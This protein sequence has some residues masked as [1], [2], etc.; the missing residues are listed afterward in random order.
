MLSTLIVTAAFGTGDTLTHSVTNETY[1]I[2]GPVDEVLAWDTDKEA[3]PE[4]KQTISL[5]DLEALKAQFAGDT[6]INAWLP[7]LRE[8]VPVQNIR[9]R[10]ND[11]NPRITASRELDTAP[12]GGL[13]DTAGRQVTLGMGDI[14]VN[15]EL[16]SNIEARVG[17][18]VLLFYRGE[19]IPLTVVAIVPNTLL[20]GTN[21]SA[22]RQGAAVNFD[23]L[24]A[25]TGR[26]GSADFV[27]I[28][29]EGTTRSDL[30]QSELVKDRLEAALAGTPYTVETIK[31]DNVEQA[32]LLGNVFTTVFVMFGL[33]SIAAGVLLIFLIFVMLAAERK[34]EMGMA[35]AVGAKRKQIVESFLA[36]GMGYD[37][38]SAVV[39]MFA[40][41]GVAAAM[42]YF[43]KSR[44]GDA[45]GLDL[46]F[47]ISPRSLI[48]AVC[49]GIIITFVVVFFAS[50]RASR[51]NIVSAIRDLPESKPHN[52]E[53]ATAMGYLRGGLNGM[54]SFGFLIVGLLGI[55]RLPELMPFWLVTAMFG[56]AGPWLAMVRNHN[57]G[58][59]AAIR[60]VG[61]RLPSWP[62]LLAL[63]VVGIPLALIGYPLAMLI[64]RFTR[65]RRPSRVATGW[66]IAGILVAPV[67][68]A[69]S[70]LQDRKRPV[71][72]AVG[73][74][75][76]SFLAGILFVEWGLSSDRMAWFALGLSFLV[77]WLAVTLTY[78]RVPA[79]PVY[80]VSSVVLMVMWYLLP[81]GRL[82]FLFGELNADVEMFFVT[83]AVLITAGTFIIIYNA[84]IILPLLAR[85][86]D[87]FG[88]ITPAV[89]T[90]V[91]YP[92][93]S[94]GRTGLTIA[95]IGL[96]V[97]V[98]SM[99]SAMN[100][101][102]ERAFL[103]ADA[104]G[105]FD[106]RVLMN[107][108]NR[109]EDLI[110]TLNEANARP[111]NPR[112]VDTGAI[113][114]VGQVR[115]ANPGE[116]DIEDPDWAS[117]D[118]A[119]RKDDERWKHYWVAG[120]DDAFVQRQEIPLRHRAAGYETDAAV[121]D[122]LRN[123]A[124]LAIIPAVL[125]D[126]DGGFGDDGGG[127]D[128]LQLDS[129]LAVDGF[130]PYT[131]KL[132]NRS[133]GTIREVT[134]IGQAKDSAST[135]W[136]AIIVQRSV[137]ELTFPD[138]KG[139]E[140]FLSLKPGTDAEDFAKDLEST[141]VQAQADS[142]DDIISEFSAI[143]RT[144][145][146]MFQGFLALGLLVG[147]AA[148]GV[149]SL[150]AVVERR[151]QIGM[152][153]AIGYQR[154]MVQLSFLLESGFIALSGIVLGLVLGVS[155]AANLFT[156]GEFGSTTKGLAFT[157]P[158]GEILGMTAFAFV[159]AMVM[160]YLPARAA[161]R[162]AVAEALRYE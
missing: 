161:S 18:T 124:S 60:K 65:E 102:F 58:A 140:F 98:L 25:L 160:T 131:L 141:L 117:S 136:G 92:L 127:D 144:F 7:M 105:G 96:I 148:L 129:D 14:A 80:T 27:A 59:P 1:T 62:Y 54:A 122:A 66:L 70:A 86:G 52:P 29:N 39:G 48:V 158:W 114:A 19:P 104:K 21:D 103:G 43:V 157:V 153:R 112:P 138:S 121:W 90:A 63:T 147:I 24:A 77:L 76:V 150:R 17:D 137:V 5:T 35:R 34:P 36:E 41:I 11:A 42:V 154:S 108:N 110:A 68:A 135:F 123:D 23:F 69:L 74:A 152:L 109:T 87:R 45:L 149:I 101:N 9:T 10:L 139:Q 95:M 119:G 57:F 47:D 93:T 83:G 38:G 84:D 15:K 113:T 130:A 143:N 33:F 4:D 13:R 71:N 64:V 73:M 88:R 142:L 20:G 155:F 85:A 107:G 120:V 2:L 31:K 91:A 55:F 6:S 145:L 32:E 146:Q 133:T 125:T 81:G 100:S 67:G 118:P 28:S 162:I 50:W 30:A 56:L 51:L 53:D 115:I 106:A 89:K 116:V 61:D 37:L 151:Q 12:F 49:I 79:R 44:A 159:A 134:V 94:R 8:Y 156:S 99:Q 22:A 82:E 97:F 46:R 72:W 40:G 75:V 132:R 128:V 126:G 78:F 111:G 26:T 3:A 16:A